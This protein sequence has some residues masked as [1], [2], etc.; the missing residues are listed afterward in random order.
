MRHVTFLAAALLLAF[1]VSAQTVT[2]AMSGTVVDSTGQVLPGASVTIVNE[3]T[4]EERTGTTNDV[5]DFAFPALVPGP[6]TI[7]VAMSGFKP[8]EIRSN[9]VLANN[10]LAVGLLH[11][12]LGELTEVVSVSAVGEALATT[13]TSHQAVLD[14]KQV[15][16]LSIRGRDPISL[17]KILPGVSLLANDQETFGGGFA[18]PVPN[19]QGG[20]GQT[21]YVDG[22]NA[23]DGG[24]GGNF[25]GATNLD[26]IQEVNVQMSAYTA[27]YGMKGGAQVNFVTKRGGSEYH[28]TAYTYQRH[29]AFNATNY[30]N[31]KE[32]VAK[33]EYRYST[34]GGNLGGQEILLLLFGR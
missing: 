26:A 23:G 28:G 19:I 20:R 27:E 32:G 30:F 2:G 6:Y 13:Q 9:V 31:N 18:T 17:L 3:Q 4:G 10:R 16:N 14:L 15:T 12:D 1:D 8:L 33:P 21:L 29:T 34:L 22:I 7:R 25:S 24:G 5:G 11:L